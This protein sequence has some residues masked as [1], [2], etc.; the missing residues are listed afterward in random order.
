[1]ERV[2]HAFQHPLAKVLQ[3]LVTVPEHQT[4]NAVSRVVA[5]AAANLEVVCAAVTPVPRSARSRETVTK[6]IPW[7]K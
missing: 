4:F 1:M 7:S 5:A 3:F 2:E 6:L